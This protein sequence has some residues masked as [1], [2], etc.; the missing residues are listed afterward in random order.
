[1]FEFEEDSVNERSH[2]VT[3]IAPPDINGSSVYSFIVI[4]DP[5]FGASEKRHDDAFINW[6]SAQLDADDAMKPRFMVCLGDTMDSGNSS[7][8]NDYN[9]FCAKLKLIAEEKSGI[10]FAA[11]SILGNHDLYNNG[12]EVWQRKIYPHVS[13]YKFAI[14]KI[15]YYFLDSAN[16]SLGQKQIKNLESQLAADSN[17]KIIFSHYAIYAGG[18]LY[19]TI[20]DTLERNRLISDFARNNVKFVFAGHAHTNHSS[21][22]GFEERVTASYLYSRAFRLVTVNEETGAI[23]ES[24]LH[25]SDAQ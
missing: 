16:G 15:S 5:H 12:W 7:G 14:N 21:N 17:P 9:E 13:Y 24:L 10:K 6:F 25:F 1:M 3:A 23:S 19:F 4:T 22:T 11:Y 2:S 20:Q 8:A 18:I